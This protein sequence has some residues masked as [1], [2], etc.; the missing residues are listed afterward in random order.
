M[1]NIIKLYVYLA[2]R[3]NLI[4]LYAMK[5]LLRITI[6]F[7]LLPSCNKEDIIKVYSCEQRHYSIEDGKYVNSIWFYFEGTED[8]AREFEEKHTYIH[9]GFDS[10]CE[11]E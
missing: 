2:Y 6:L 3:I 11:C 7:L 4:Y 8:E 9:K 5:N 10:S 1:T